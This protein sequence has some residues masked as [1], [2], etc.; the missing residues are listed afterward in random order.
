MLLGLLGLPRLTS[1]RVS[2]GDDGSSRRTRA[3]KGAA[4]EL[5]QAQ[6]VETTVEQAEAARLLAEIDDLYKR[7]EYASALTAARRAV[8]Q[9]E[10][11]FGRESLEVAAA[12]HQV[13]KAQRKLGAFEQALS[14]YQ[15]SLAIREAELGADHVLVAESLYSMAVVLEKRGEFDEALQRYD[16]ALSITLRTQQDEPML[17]AQALNNQGLAE[18]KL[19][20]YDKAEAHLQEALAIVEDELGPDHED[21]HYPVNNL[22]GLYRAKGE[23]ERAEACYL[24]A[25]SIIETRLGPRHVEIL[26]T[27]NGLANV[28]LDK[29][30]YEQALP[31]YERALDIITE[32][33]GP[34]HHRIAVPLYTLA[35]I[36]MAQGEYESALVRHQRTLAI[37]RAH[38]PPEHPAISLSLI[39]ISQIHM[40]EGQYEDSIA[41]QEEALRS[42]EVTLGNNHP[43]VA[44]ALEQL[45]LSHWALGQ[46]ARTTDFFER[47][48]SLRETHFRLTMDL[49]TPQAKRLFLA[50][51]SGRL[52]DVIA[53]AV[54]AGA[55]PALPPAE[56]ERATRVALLM[57]LQHKGRV[58]DS[59]ASAVLSLRRDLDADAERVLE[60]YRNNRT[61]YATLMLRKPETVD[62]DSYIA[63]IQQIEKEAESLE[64]EI[65]AYGAELQG[66]A[67]PISVGAVQGTLPDGAALVEWARYR[68]REH[69]VT[70]AEQRL[71]P[72]RY[73][74]CIIARGTA[75]VWVDLG[76]AERIDSLVAQWRVQL[77]TNAA[78]VDETARALGERIMDP[79]QR[80]LQ[81]IDELYVSPDGALNLIPFAALRD[82]EGHYL[83]ERYRVHYHTSGRD[84]LRQQNDAPA[85]SEPMI[86]ANPLY[87]LPGNT[88]RH[89][90]MPLDHVIKEA[91]EVAQRYAKPTVLIGAD[92]TE[93]ALKQVRGPAVLHI[94]THG[95]F[96][97]LR[98]DEQLEGTERGLV[99]A[100]ESG[101]ALAGAN[102]CRG[103]AAVD[104]DRSVED[105]LLTALELAS[106][107]LVGTELAVLSACDTA[108]GATEI[109]DRWGTPTGQADGVYGLRRALT[110]AGAE[111][112]LMTLWK[113]DDRAA[114]QI[115]QAFYEY[116]GDGVPRSEALRQAQL[117]MLQQEGVSIRDWAPYIMMGADGP[118]VD[119]RP[120]G[121]RGEQG[122]ERGRDGCGCQGD[123]GGRD[124]TYMWLWAC[125]IAGLRGLKLRR[126]WRV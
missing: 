53:Y 111:T 97:P 32:A 104:S 69:H 107:D 5:H 26:E 63:S 126:A 76:P 68:P 73:A 2:S 46:H 95:Y 14:T 58:L 98:C 115:M 22:G 36:D 121:R 52:S 70:D 66:Q 101:L 89:D 112:Q 96:G 57:L 79:L 120:V 77:L 4:S 86:V 114:R 30:Q 90:F 28:Y 42:F 62:S 109:H 80:Y 47:A 41:L 48:I 103:L 6:G 125:L 59:I 94:A 75:P 74:A 1:A 50:N 56:R 55:N 78:T 8:A 87:D 72:P 12:L 85:R 29:K 25:L 61:R 91:R 60:R 7:G 100:L 9:H 43:D 16:R 123:P 39:S 65:E 20:A 113:V 117:G 88:R 93:H 106:L 11:T 64:R 83:L 99:P 44:K 24:R 34:K 13:A 81:G 108:V 15:R 38:L 110:L 124:D 119:A 118:M 116:L 105:G 3:D 19:G 17:R 23:H 45:A 84:R 54:D 35:L 71:G 21:V 33:F 92:A 82:E 102:G 122:A 27:L 67:T 10:R 40:L 51:I 31:L 49:D 18:R 37:R